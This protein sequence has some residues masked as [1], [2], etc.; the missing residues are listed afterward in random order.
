MPFS[1]IE[2]YDCATG[3]LK[4]R[5]TSNLAI[6]QWFSELDDCSQKKCA[7]NSTEIWTFATVVVLIKI[8]GIS[9]HISVF[10]CDCFHCLRLFCGSICQIKIPGVAGFARSTTNQILMSNLELQ[11]LCS[12]LGSDRDKWFWNIFDKLQYYRKIVQ[13]NMHLTIFQKS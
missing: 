3:Y 6:Q 7:Q 9:V 10:L 5:K 12:K 4:S 13:Y 1:D 8:M 11:L 2:R